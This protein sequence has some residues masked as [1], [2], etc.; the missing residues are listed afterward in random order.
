[1]TES[2]RDVLLDLIV[3][4]EDEAKAGRLPR[5]EQLCADHPHLLNELLARIE[6]LRRTSW[7][8]LQVEDDEDASSS[9]QSE[10]STRPLVLAGRYRLDEQIGRGVFGRVYRGFDTTLQ[11]AVAIK[12]FDLRAGFL[13]GPV[14]AYLEEAK[15]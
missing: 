14:E 5:I 4:W 2:E 7:M 9:S 1:M 6:Q 10:T 15:K 11:R 13:S 12:L 3:T 8:D